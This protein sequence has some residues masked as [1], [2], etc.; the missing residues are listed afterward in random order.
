MNQ[1][2]SKP[3]EKS[4]TGPGYDAEDV[5]LHYYRKG[6][7]RGLENVIEGGMI[8]FDRRKL[9]REDLPA[10][11][12]LAV[13]PNLRYDGEMKEAVRRFERK[14]ILRVLTKT[15]NGKKLADQKIGRS[16]SP[17]YRKM[18]EP[19]IGGGEK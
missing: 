11:M 13:D 9:A 4:V 1:M 2:Q 16:L 18:S 19:G 6:D 14:F 10:N 5:L 8:L 17:L 3:P 12:C 15:K 7:I